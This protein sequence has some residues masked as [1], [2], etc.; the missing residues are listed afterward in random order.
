MNFAVAPCRLA[1]ISFRAVDSRGVPLGR[2]AQMT[3]TRRD[4]ASLA[5][6]SRQTSRREDGTFLFDGIQPGEYY[7]VVTT[8]YGM[9]EAAYVNA[10]F[11]RRTCR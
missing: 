7:L 2:E 8:S 5:S 9:E 11:A 4:D 1:R 6:S 10:R 3:L